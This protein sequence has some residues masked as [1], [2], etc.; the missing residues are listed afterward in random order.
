MYIGHYSV[1]SE[2]FFGWGEEIG[3]RFR[4]MGRRM[5]PG[6]LWYWAFRTYLP[7]CKSGLKNFFS[8]KMMIDMN[9]LG[10]NSPFFEGEILMILKKCPENS[11]F[12]VFKKSISIIIFSKKK[13]FF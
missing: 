13:N 5:G 1:K 8:A 7:L 4:N 12:R 10:E 2:H 9:I 3:L 6:G 11:V